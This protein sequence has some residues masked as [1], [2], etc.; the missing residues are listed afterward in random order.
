LVTLDSS[1]PSFHS[2]DARSRPRSR[3]FGDTDPT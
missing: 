2:D 3:S 1:L